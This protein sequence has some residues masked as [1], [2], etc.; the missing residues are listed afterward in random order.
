MLRS[1]HQQI[2]LYQQ[3]LIAPYHDSEV[4][5]GGPTKSTPALV[6]AI[7]RIQPPWRELLKRSVS[8][9]FLQ[10][11]VQRSSKL[12]LLTSVALRSQ[13]ASIGKGEAHANTMPGSMTPISKERRAAVG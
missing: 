3:T 12:V 13:R 5:S 1:Q 4:A 2:E 9:Q 7:G 10:L 8:P 6:A 11:R